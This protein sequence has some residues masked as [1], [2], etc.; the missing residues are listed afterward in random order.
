MIMGITK[1]ATA[2]PSPLQRERDFWAAVRVRRYYDHR[3]SWLRP[4]ASGP[5]AID[6]FSVLSLHLR[7]AL[8]PL[9][10]GADDASRARA[11]TFRWKRRQRLVSSRLGSNSANTT[12]KK[13]TETKNNGLS[14]C[15]IFAFSICFR[16]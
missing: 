2:A 10:A 3:P 13:A 14:P 5:L 9:S 11:A 6:V 8:C 1:V 7:R 4:A 15:C 12:K 16:Y